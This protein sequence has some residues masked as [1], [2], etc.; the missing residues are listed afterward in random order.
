[1]VSNLLAVLQLSYLVVDP[2]LSELSKSRPSGCE[3][4]ACIDDNG[5]PRRLSTSSAEAA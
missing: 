5:I 2:V 4:G 3:P 1:M